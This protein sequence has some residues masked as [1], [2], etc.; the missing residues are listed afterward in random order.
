M[1]NILLVDDDDVTRE[2]INRGLKRAGAT[3]P[4]TSAEDGQ[5]AIEILRGANPAK[6]IEAP[7]VVLLDLNMPRMNGFEFL[8][9]L[10][11][12]TDLRN[13]PV[14]VLT[15]SE[16]EGDKERATRCCIAGFMV[17]S[18]LGPQ[19]SKLAAML[20]GYTGAMMA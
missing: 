10:R 13:T 6:H 19:Y 20:T 18:N 16:A 9:E 4:V 8:Q 12:D 5:E 7:L 14:F 17:K 15:S 11:T 1:V 2:C 3:F